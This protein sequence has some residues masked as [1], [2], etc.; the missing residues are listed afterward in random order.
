[1]ADEKRTST[2]DVYTAGEVA[3]AAGV[4][5]SR[6]EAL[7]AGGQFQLLGATAA[8]FSF[9]DAVQAVRTLREGGGRE[10]TL[11]DQPSFQHASAKLPV[12]VSTAFHAGLAATLILV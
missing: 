6:V 2:V 8:Y 1:M 11:F 3:E 10:A 4:P 12:A 7:I 5:V 9:D